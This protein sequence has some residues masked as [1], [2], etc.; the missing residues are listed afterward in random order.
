ME[1]SGKY[2]SDHS[3][4][5]LRHNL[6]FQNKS[7]RCV[8]SQ[9]HKKSLVPA[10]ACGFVH[11]L[12]QQE[13]R[14]HLTLSVGLGKVNSSLIIPKQKSHQTNTATGSGNNQWTFGLPQPSPTARKTKSCWWNGLAGQAYTDPQNVSS[15]PWHITALS[16]VLVKGGRQ[17]LTMINL[18]DNSEKKDIANHIS[19]FILWTYMW[20]RYC[21]LAKGLAWFSFWATEL[22]SEWVSFLLSSE[23][24]SRMN[25]RQ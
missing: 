11:F 21:C 14:I 17:T 2:H 7:H 10:K 19:Y 24:C 23:V 18:W 22:P 16:S 3:G 9:D 12:W 5:F 13:I 1:T 15:S 4:F 20:L 8:L 25:V 6:D